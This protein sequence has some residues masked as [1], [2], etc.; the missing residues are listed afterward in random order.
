M[1]PSETTYAP[2]ETSPFFVFFIV[3]FID[4]TCYYMSLLASWSLVISATSSALWFYKRVSPLPSPLS[5]MLWL[6]DPK[7]GTTFRNRIT[8]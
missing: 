8:Q 5:H 7:E 4:I 6:L 2:G 1:W 3:I